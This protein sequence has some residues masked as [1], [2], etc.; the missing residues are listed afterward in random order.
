MATAPEILTFMVE[1]LTNA[2]HNET[3][4]GFDDQRIR[5]RKQ[6]TLASTHKKS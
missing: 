6:D 3:T 4:M 1:N 2:I 5:G